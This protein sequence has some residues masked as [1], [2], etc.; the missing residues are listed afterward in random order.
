MGHYLHMYVHNVIFNLLNI[1]GRNDDNTANYVT[2]AMA[3]LSP[4]YF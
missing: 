3:E 2:L 4:M 1:N